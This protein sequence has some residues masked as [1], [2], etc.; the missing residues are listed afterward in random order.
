MLACRNCRI[1]IA[2][3]KGCAICDP[4][5][6][7]LVSTDEAADQAPSLAEV[8][9][10]SVVALRR[11][12]RYW[13]KVLKD[14]P[15]DSDGNRNLVFMTNSIAK[16]LEAARKLQ[17]DGIAAVRNMSFLER[18]K[19]FVSWYAQ[20]PPAYRTQVREQVEKHELEVSQPLELTA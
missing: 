20:L 15:A 8:G 3:T 18:A 10:E 11:Q 17:D 7:Q 12:V 1:P 4:L 9:G 2:A 14:S 5:R 6:L 13:D 16:M 19:L